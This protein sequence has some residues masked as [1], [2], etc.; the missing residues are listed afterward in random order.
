MSQSHRY[1]SARRPSGW[2]SL[3]LLL[4]FSDMTDIDVTA[5]E[6]VVEHGG[7]PRSGE[8]RSSKSV[9]DSGS[10]EADDR[11]CFGA[12]LVRQVYSKGD[13]FGDVED[14]MD[15]KEDKFQTISDLLPD[16]TSRT[17]ETQPNV[18]EDDELPKV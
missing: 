9:S 10:L 12:L 11:L 15:G 1:L 6:Q 14:E 2:E 4:T 16:E 3:E 8:E 7:C 18:N 17:T 13:I 5:A